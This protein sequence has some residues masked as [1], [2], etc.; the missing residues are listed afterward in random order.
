VDEQVPAAVVRGLRR[1]GVD[2]LSVVEAGLRSRSD[3]EIIAYAR[4]EQRVILTQDR[5]FLRLHAQ[6]STHA[7]IVFA[8]QGTSI[9]DVIRS[10]LF[11]AE[12]LTAEEMLGHVE[13]L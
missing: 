7:G 13:L 8:R 3:T 11:I 6:G 9:G 1:R 10:L 12:T 4:R 2:V 5:D